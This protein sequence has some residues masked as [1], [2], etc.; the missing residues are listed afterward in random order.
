MSL[1]SLE[2]LHI[3]ISSKRVEKLQ[4]RIPDGSE[5]KRGVKDEDRSIVPIQLIK[6]CVVWKLSDGPGA[7]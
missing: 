2:D 4:I 5:P 6:V 7:L 1:L 3:T